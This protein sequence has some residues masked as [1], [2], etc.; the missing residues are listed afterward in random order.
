MKITFVGGGP[1]SNKGAVYVNSPPCKS[2]GKE[3][4][5]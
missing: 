3:T 5:K 4:D 2:P 1:A